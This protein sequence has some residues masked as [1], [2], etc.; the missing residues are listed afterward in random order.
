MTAAAF[1]ISQD[2]QFAHGESP[3]SAG[4]HVLPWTATP[5][6]LVPLAGMISDRIGRRPLM[7]AG[8]SI[9]GVGL[10]SFA[11][12]T[13]AEFSYW[14]AVLTLVVAG[15]GVSIT[16]PA[17]SATVMNSVE[18]GDLG[19]ASAVN[20]VMQRFGTAFGVALATAVFASNGSLTSAHAFTAGFRPAL[21]AVAMLSFIGTAAAVAVGGRARAARPALETV[22]SP[23][24]V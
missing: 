24:A 9:Q 5:V 12:L 11:A 17:T 23:T 3:L 6:F 8:T 7:L 19:K 2:F 13:G 1:L 22:T 16:L 4:L 20:G 18:A 10:L 21:V 15:I 14:P